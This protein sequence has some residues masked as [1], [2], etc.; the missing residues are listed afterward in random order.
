[1]KLRWMLI[2][3]LVLLLTTDMPTHAE[4]CS[5]AADLEAHQIS[6]CEY[7]G[8][9]RAMWL[10]ETIANWTGLTT[11]AVRTDAP[12]YTDDD[13]SRDQNLDWKEND[14]IDFV[15][16]DPWLSDDDTDIEYVYL[17]L[18]DEYATTI[19]SAVQIAD[20]WKAHVNDFIW[21]SNA[22]ARSL[23]EQGALPPVTSFGAVNEY[24]LQIDAQLTTEI[25]GALAPGMPEQALLMADLPIRTTAHGY[26]A[27]AAQFYVVAYSLAAQVDRSL[28]PVEQIVW[29][30]Q[31]ARRYIP[32]NSKTAD[33]I[34]FVLQDYMANPD[35]DDWESTR[36]AIH[37]RYH[38]NASE[39]GFVYHDWTESSVNLATGVMAL[40]YGEGD[41]RRTVQIGTLSGWDSD[42]GTAT[43]G[44]LLG[45]LYG[46][47]YLLEQFAEVELSDRYRIHRTRPT[48][49]DYVPDDSE[50]EDTFSLMAERM[51]PIAEQA[52]M[53][54]GGSI[55]GDTWTLP[56]YPTTDYLQLNP[57]EQ[58]S[59]RSANVQVPL[60]GGMVQVEISGE[61]VNRRAALIADGA[62]MDYSGREIRRPAGFYRR[63]VTEDEIT[64]TVTYS[65]DV[66]V[67]VIRLIEGSTNAF[68]QLD[69]RILVDGE[70][71]PITS[72]TEFEPLPDPTI[73]YQLIDIYLAEPVM[74][75]GIRVTG[76]I[77]P[78]ARLPEVNIL[79]LDA[80]SD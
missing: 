35:K 38:G 27:H 16:Q 67:A 1:M 48:M 9:L 34:D 41:F 39:Y 14:T 79:E 18:L 30:V 47:D 25:F 75:Q 6:R 13:W 21:V 57:L 19:L 50:A 44:G 80:L 61:V 74:A 42:N 78:E 11:E 62:E 71:Q 10:G 73:P 2:P 58:I 72:G 69:A 60:T 59:Q 26:A 64:L 70:W 52:V 4:D 29:L 76:T 8:H 7:A 63:S 43:M 51:L 65:Q 28:S 68:S 56:A 77:S 22:Q 53:E 36:D 66:E 40:L 55:D 5:P 17:H 33:I 45:L 54:A 49:P 31:E 12:F 20:G 3:L 46:Y 37:E 23:M 24:F 32:D 15:L